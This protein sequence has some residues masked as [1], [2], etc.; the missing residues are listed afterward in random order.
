M[1]T[2]KLYLS[3]DSYRRVAAMAEKSN[4]DVDD[5]AT[6][7]VMHACSV[8]EAH[9]EEMGNR[10]RVRAELSKDR[11]RFGFLSTALRNLPDGAFRQL[12]EALV[13]EREKGR[14]E[15]S[16]SALR[17]LTALRGKKP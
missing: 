12:V 13:L 6:S 3:D 5:W 11:N 15:G 14:Q 4:A 7:A 10:D 8:D 2:V 1:K 9:W 16:T 17:R